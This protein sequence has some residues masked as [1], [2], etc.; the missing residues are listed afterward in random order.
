[1]P[2]DRNKKFAVVAVSQ[3]AHELIQ[4][5]EAAWCGY[6]AAD[7]KDQTAMGNA[8]AALCQRRKELY[9]YLSGLEFNAVI[10]RPIQRRFD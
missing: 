8:Y 1:M 3:A 2:Q 7:P 10:D 5:L 4:D 9:Q 6:F